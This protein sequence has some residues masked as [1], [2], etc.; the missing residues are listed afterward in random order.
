MTQP[1]STLTRVVPNAK[2]S[3][4]Y[5]TSR[6]FFFAKTSAEYPTNL[7]PYFGFNSMFFFLG[8][9][10]DWSISFH[11]TE[12]CFDNLED[13]PHSEALHGQST[14]RIVRQSAAPVA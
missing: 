10:V 12:S 6:P 5:S 7:T 11:P 8:V 9:R 14:R 13:E 2:S 3:I 4:A 1:P